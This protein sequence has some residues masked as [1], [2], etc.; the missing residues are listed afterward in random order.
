MKGYFNNKYY[1]NL[2][3][4]SIN[5]R[6]VQRD[7]TNLNNV[8]TDLCKEGQTTGGITWVKW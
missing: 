2:A 5:W 7:C 3:N 4:D 1:S 6:Q 8:D